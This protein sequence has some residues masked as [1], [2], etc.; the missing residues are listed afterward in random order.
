MAIAV[1]RPEQA[2]A[3]EVAARVAEFR[4]RITVAELEEVDQI[5]RE[6]VD[7]ADHIAWIVKEGS[8]AGDDMDA[9]VEEDLGQAA[10]QIDGNAMTAYFNH[11]EAERNRAAA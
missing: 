6:C 8:G 1:K 10:A 2:T 11:V 4:E 3:E 5:V 7:Q 9:A